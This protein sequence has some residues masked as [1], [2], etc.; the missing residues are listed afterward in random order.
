MGSVCNGLLGEG[1]GGCGTLV[2]AADSRSLPR[3]SFLSLLFWRLWR[4]MTI[5]M[6]SKWR[7]G[8]LHSII[9]DFTGVIGVVSRREYE[10]A[11]DIERDDDA[12]E[13]EA[14]DVSRVSAPKLES[15]EVSGLVMRNGSKSRF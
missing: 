4:S 12:V 8:T 1:E 14:M 9:S 15:M 2:L 6:L 11:R 5:S 3:L 13:V 10:F 7:N